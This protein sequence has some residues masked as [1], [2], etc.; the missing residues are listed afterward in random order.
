MD[1][2]ELL[3]LAIASLAIGFVFASSQLYRLNI[4]SFS[5]VFSIAVLSVISHEIAH[6]QVARVM[7]CYSRYVLHPIGLLITL[8]SSLPFV[9][10]KFIM[11]GVTVI[12]PR[13]Y[14]YLELKRIEGVTSLA[15][16][17]TNIV[18][19]MLGFMLINLYPGL[20]A[21]YSSYVYYLVY[22][23]AWIALF[24]LLPIPPLDGSKVFRWNP[25]L[26]LLSMVASVGLFLTTIIY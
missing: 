4:V 15:G 5:S 9:P 18:L 11:P 23:N 19:A 6:R 10:I 13:T 16:P 20:P 26:Y 2:D 1:Y 21:S 24:N 22:V 7:N 14:D 3:S 8:V 12:M 25:M 17:V